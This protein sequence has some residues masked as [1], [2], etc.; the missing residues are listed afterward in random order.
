MGNNNY[1]VFTCVLFYK[2]SLIPICDIDIK[3]EKKAL[4]F[5]IICVCCV[6][7][8][9]SLSLLRYANFGVEKMGCLTLKFSLLPDLGLVTSGARV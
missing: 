7:I 2:L 4:C 3:K 8:L 9:L 6:S 5:V 1:Y